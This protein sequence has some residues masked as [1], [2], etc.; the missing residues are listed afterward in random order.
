MQQKLQSYYSNCILS[1]TGSS[2]HQNK[3]VLCD[4]DYSKLSPF[5][6]VTFLTSPSEG[7]SV[8]SDV[9]ILRGGGTT[10]NKQ[11]LIRCKLRIDTKT[12]V[13]VLVAWR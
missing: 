7:K 4:S 6:G 5:A 9:R 10:I 11:N 2:V 3:L 8:M 1:R 12:F 13:L